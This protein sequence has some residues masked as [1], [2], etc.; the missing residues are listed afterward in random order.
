LKILALQRGFFFDMELESI[1]KKLSGSLERITTDTRTIAPGDVFF[2]LKGPNFNGNAFAQDALNKGAIYAVVDEISDSES[3]N[4]ILVEDVLQC[5]QS[6]ARLHKRKMGIRTIGITGTN[7]K[8]TTKELLFEVCTRHFRT[9]ATK[10]NLNNHIGVPLTLL[11][12]RP[13]H[14]I[15]I[16]EMGANKPGDIAELCELGDPDLGLITSIGKAHLEGYENFDQLIETK[17]ALFDHVQAKGGV[18]FFNL[19]SEILSSAYNSLP[20]QIGFGDVSTPGIYKFSLQASHPVVKLTQH[21]PLKENSF[22]S[23]LYGVHN[24]QNLIAAITL[25]E[26][27]GVP[28]SQIQEALVAYLP[29]NMRSQVTQWKNNKI[30]LDAYNANPDSMKY[31]LMSLAEYNKEDKWAILGQMA[32]LGEASAREHRMIMDLAMDLGIEKL[33]FIG[34]DWP[35]MIG[36]QNVH[37]FDTLSEGSDFLNKNLPQQKTILI[38]GSRSIGLEGILSENQ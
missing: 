25:G 6:L 28:V 38:K 30:L 34:K 17:F 12:L 24:Y 32:E 27:L 19:N 4:L 7:G 37:V 33:I 13:E 1:Y 35:R 15:L 9:H 26:Y 8:T 10:G 21:A 23:N 5:L 2:A 22:S 36:H 14:E 18:C 3:E 20:G 16:L 29:A 31:A 11:K